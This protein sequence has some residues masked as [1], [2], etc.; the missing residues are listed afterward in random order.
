EGVDL[1]PNPYNSVAGFSI[2]EHYFFPG[3]PVMAQPMARWVLDTYY[4]EHFH[5]YRSEQKAVY[6]LGQ[7]ESKITPIMEKIEREF[8]GVRTFSLPSVACET[9]DGKTVPAQIE[10]G[11]KAENQACEQLDAAW[12]VALSE[13]ANIQAIMKDTPFEAE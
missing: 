4:A 5:Q 9:A 1:I 2:R 7:A 8:V 6:L 3:F 10:F 12:Q 13:L 11:I